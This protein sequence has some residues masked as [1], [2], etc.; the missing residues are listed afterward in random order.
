MSSYPAL[1]PLWLIKSHL[2]FSKIFASFCAAAALF[3]SEV[4]QT[5]T[6]RCWLGV[7][8]LLEL[9]KADWIL[10]KPVLGGISGKGWHRY[11]FEEQP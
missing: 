1:S 6:T 10:M 4:S 2:S 7:V 9:R 5:L 3:T 11:T 8:L